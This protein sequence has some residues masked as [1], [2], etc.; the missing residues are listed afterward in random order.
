MNPKE[1]GSSNHP[2][3]RKKEKLPKSKIANEKLKK[4]IFNSLPS[5]NVKEKIGSRSKTITRKKLKALKKRINN[6]IFTKYNASKCMLTILNT[7]K[8]RAK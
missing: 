8:T 4:Y 2:P 5:C 6:T 1:P 7:I 3:P